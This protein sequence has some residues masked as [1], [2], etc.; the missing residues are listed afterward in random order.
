MCARA[1]TTISHSHKTSA[2]YFCD[3]TCNSLLPQIND[4]MLGIE[5]LELTLPSDLQKQ[6]TCEVK[7]TNETNDYY[8]FIIETRCRRY[9]ARPDKGIVSPQSSCSIQITM[10]AQ[11]ST[12]IDDFIVK[13]T[14]VDGDARAKHI[15]EHMSDKDPSEV[16]EV[17]LAVV[18]YNPEKSK[19]NASAEVFSKVG[20]IR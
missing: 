10:Q 9:H 4:D 6:I 13:S 3:D 19:G 12:T 8:A 17:T 18:I 20:I 5:P 11:Q 7:L 16:D 15:I 14:I 2:I 1:H